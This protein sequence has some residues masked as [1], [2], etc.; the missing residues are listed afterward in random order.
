MPAQELEDLISTNAV[1]FYAIADNTTLSST[2]RE[3]R[4]RSTPDNSNIARVPVLGGTTSEEGRIYAVVYNDTRAYIASSFPRITN[5]QT[6]TLLE[7]FAIG[8]P[9]IDTTF[10][11]ITYIITHYQ[12]QCTWAIVAEE[13]RE[14]G[15]P[16]WRYFWN[17]SFENLELFPGSGVYHASDIRPVFGNIDPDSTEFEIMLSQLA[18]STWASFAKGLS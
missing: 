15:I 12:F 10:D 13:T 5:E 8:S 7:T 17:A 18:Q 14:V 1:P 3:D 9:G 16:I 6:E 2:A 4:Q 11:Q